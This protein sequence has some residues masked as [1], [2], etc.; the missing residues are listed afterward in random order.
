MNTLEY[1]K[2]KKTKHD[3]KPSGTP[4]R[5]KS[6]LVT[7]TMVTALTLLGGCA[8]ILKTKNPGDS[9]AECNAETT[10]LM[11][12][13]KDKK[14][15]VRKKAV[16]LLGKRGG[17]CAVPALLMAQNDGN[18]EVKEAVSWALAEFKDKRVVPTLMN[19]VRTSNNKN[20]KLHA[21][22]ALGEFRDVRAIPVLIEAVKG[23]RSTAV[24]KKTAAKPAAGNKKTAAKG[25]DANAVKKETPVKKTA[26]K[27]AA[28]NKTAVKKTAA[29]GKD[30]NAEK[31]T[32]VKKETPVKKTA[33]V[34]KETAVKKT[35]AKP[36]AAK[37]TATTEDDAD[38][39]KTAVNALEKIVK[40]NP[41]HRALLA[42]VPALVGVLKYKIDIKRVAVRTL[43]TVGK[44]ATAELV[45][46]LK[47]TNAA[48][49]AAAAKALGIIKDGNAVD[50][51]VKSL[52]D[53]SWV[54]RKW[55]AEALGRIMDR[56]ALSALQNAKE[57]DQNK[58]VREA[59]A[60]A[61]NSIEGK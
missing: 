11:K 60:D 39:R 46:A 48:I 32:A 38:L 42:A 44:P 31:K 7:T 6:V 23:I 17:Y 4:F 37:T 55:A 26:A 33:V 61:I 5:G 49:R 43:V 13:L 9:R 14:P 22:W 30:A 36:A 47:N 58:E 3:K 45:R 2:R 34:K 15:E 52:G 27:P 8:G 1:S 53:G 40:A 50:A 25:K 56:K 41:N 28:G 10:K 21:L 19:I 51:L 20:V 57:K 18:P 16:Y 54:V 35:A 59:A 29:K 12:D 24:V